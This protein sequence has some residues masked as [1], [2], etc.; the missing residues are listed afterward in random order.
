MEA[1]VKQISP[2][3]R[4]RVPADQSLPALLQ[5]AASL[6]AGSE[7]G[8]QPGWP[9]GA[10]RPPGRG[11]SS[12]LGDAEHLPPVVGW[13]WW[14]VSAAPGSAQRQVKARLSLLEQRRAQVVMP[15]CVLPWT[16]YLNQPSPLSEVFPFTFIPSA[17]LSIKDGVQ[18]SHPRPGSGVLPFKNVVL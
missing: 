17:E 11:G 1:V 15:G 12:G 13:T 8:V 4:V 14:L 18:W 2:I 6:P 7:A 3:V 5:T 9:A 10:G 16:C